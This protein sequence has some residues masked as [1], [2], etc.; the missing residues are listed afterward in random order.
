FSSHAGY[1]LRL[2]G[3]FAVGMPAHYYVEQL[4]LLLFLCPAVAMAG[5]L[6]VWRR[7]GGDEAATFLG[8]AAGSLV[9]MQAVWK[10]QIGVLDDWNLYA[11]GGMLAGLFIWRALAHA[12]RTTAM[13]V[14]AAVIAA[15]GWLHTY[16]WIVMNHG[17]TRG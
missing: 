5:A 8:I 17:W 13:R 11:I 10:S 4:E 15:A 2:N 6:A 14:A 12:A 16:A 9:L 3:V 7:F 1:A